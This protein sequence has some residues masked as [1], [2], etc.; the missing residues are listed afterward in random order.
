MCCQGCSGKIYQALMGVE[1]VRDAAVDF[2]TR[3]AKVVVKET[4]PGEL[5]LTALRFDKYSAV[6]RQP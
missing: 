3:A 1:G 6:Q 5:F 4:T 2:D